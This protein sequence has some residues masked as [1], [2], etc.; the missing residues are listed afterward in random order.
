MAIP[1]PPHFKFTTRAPFQLSASHVNTTSDYRMRWC[2]NF[3]QYP[4]TQASQSVLNP[5]DIRVTCSVVNGC[6]IP[7]V[8]YG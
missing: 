7:S 2:V 8:V 3:G 4:V 5:T 6:N 1:P